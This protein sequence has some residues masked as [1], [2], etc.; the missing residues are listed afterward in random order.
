MP[1]KLK[2]GLKNGLR[3]LRPK[4]SPVWNVYL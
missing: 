3:K 1:P 2:I 4:T